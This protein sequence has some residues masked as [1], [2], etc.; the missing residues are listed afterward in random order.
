MASKFQIPIAFKSDPRGI[1]EAESALGG[2]GKKLAGIGLA[3][4]GAFAVGSVFRFAKESILAAE[5]AQQ[6]N[7]ILVQVAKTTDTFGAN[8]TGG[9][10]RLLKFADA[11]E[12]VIGVEAELIKETQA[13]LLSFKAVGSSAGEAGGNFD[14][15]TKAAFDMAAVLKTDARGS[16]VQLG[17]ALE[18]PIKGVT[19]LARAG[20]TFTE[21][22]REQIKVLVES[23]NL[24][25]A[26][27]LILTEVESQYGGAAEAAAL[28]SQKIT[29]AFGQVQDALGMALAPAFQKFAT[30]FIEEIVPPLTKFF[31]EDF[32]VMIASF[33][34][35]W[36]GLV[37]ALAPVG[38]A[39]KEALAI[40]ETASVLES[41]LNSIANLPESPLFKQLVESMVQLVPSLLMLIPP[42]TELVVELIPLLV[43]L[44]PG[45]IW[46]IELL[47]GLFG[48]DGLAGAIN[49]ATEGQWGWIDSVKNFEIAA[50]IVKTAVEALATPWVTLTK[51]INDA[52]NALVSWFGLNKTP[53]PSPSLSDSSKPRAVGGPVSAMD[54]YMV[55]ERGPELF[56]P[57][58]G[59]FI[60]PNNR[61]GGSSG[62]TYNIT[63]NAGMG[64]NGAQLGQEIV[65]LIKKYE[66]AS[67]PVFASA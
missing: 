64:T 25:A 7:D 41:L 67:G 3:V 5:R 35:A 54:S 26:Q 29:L 33:G 13:V 58:A 45:L 47:T 34:E 22:Q 49:E 18:N 2:F 50:G 48:A 65:S 57:G 59:G 42:L 11:Q 9:T 56:T 43:A 32:P 4:A 31:E 53:V 51:A 16:A 24:L 30:F 62:A 55:G 46:F 12:L 39:L 40:P 61:L 15:A 20:T 19:A 8:L 36:A 60:T 52:Y 63:V 10:D 37:E 14:R 28:S 21:Q 44:L 6:F 38:A 27:E 66:R 23:G 1:K 17:K